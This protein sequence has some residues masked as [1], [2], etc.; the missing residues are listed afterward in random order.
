MKRTIKQSLLA[1]TMLGLGLLATVFVSLQVKQSID[2]D[3]MRQ[4]SFTCDQVTLKIRERLGDYALTLRGGV[5]LFNASN[6]VSREE[7]KAYTETLRAQDSIPGLQGIGFSLFI[8]RDQLADHIANIR[9]EGFPE[10]NVHPSGER[11]LYTSIIYLEPFR[12]R[13]M[14]AFGYDMFS[15]PVRRAAMEQARDTGEA[16]LSGKVQLVQETGAEVQAGTLMYIPVYRNGMPHDTVEQ[17]RAALIGWV[18]SPFR[19]NDLMAGILGDWERREGQAIRLEIYDGAE[20]TLASLLFASKTATT[21]DMH[22][23]F[24]LQRTIDFNGHQWLLEFDRIGTPFGIGYATAWATLAGGFALSGLLF[25]LMLSVINTQ[26][27]AA[28]IARNLTEEIRRREQLLMESEYRW[29]FALEG[30]GDGVWDWNLENDKVFFSK[31]WK[32]MLGFAEDEIGDSLDEWKNRLHPDDKDETL[33]AVQDYLNGKVPVYAHEHRMRCKGGSYKWML[34]QGM[35]VS[36]DEAGKPLRMIGTDSDFTEFK[37]LEESLRQ[38]QRELQE[39]QRIAQVGIW[40]MD[41]ATQ[42]VKWSEELYR[43]LRLSPK[44]PPPPFPEQ[45]GLFTPSSWECLNMAVSRAK[46]QGTPYELELEIIRADGSLGWTLAKGE[47]VRDASGAI[48]GLRGVTADI[49]ESK[50]ADLKLKA[51]HMETQRFR[52]ALDYVSS[53]IYMK[54]TQSRYLYA[55]RATLELFG[56]SAEELVGSD[57]YRFF[58]A[59]TAKRLREIDAR[60]FQGE[61]TTE[62]VDV[63]Y[64]KGGRRVYLEIKTPIYEDENNQTVGGLLGISTN[65]TTLKEHEQYLEHIAHYDALT[66]LAN[67][68]LFADRLHQSMA[69]ALR[70]GKQLA[71]AYI[72]LDGFKAVND[73]HGHE[74]GDH[75]LMAVAKNMKRT[76]REGDSLA[77]LGGDEFVAMLQDLS[78]TENSTPMLTRLLKAASEPVTYQKKLLQVSASVGVTFFPQQEEVDADQLLRQADHAMYQAK[79]AGKNKFHLFDLEQDRL[80][81]GHHESL[82]HIRQALANHEFV[83]YYQPKANIRTGM[84][85]GVE[86]LIRWRH[87]D[88]GLLPPAVFLPVIED[89][90]LSVEFGEWVINTTLSQMER[91][92]ATGLDIPVSVNVSAR[93]LQQINFVER[94]KISLAAHPAIE[95]S[96]LELEILETSALADLG[97]VCR[98]MEDCRDIGVSFAL[99][100][101]GTGYSSLTYLK[102]L[103]ADTLKIDQTFVHGMLEDPEDLAILEGVLGLAT[104]FHRKAIAEGVETVEHG[105]MLL[106]LGCDIAQGYGI[107]RPMPADQLSDWVSS[108]KPDPC[109]V[110]L[111]AIDRADLPLLYASVELRAWAC[112]FEAS[113]VGGQISSPPLDPHQCRFGIWLDGGGLADRVLPPVRQAIDT[114][115][116]RIHELAAEFTHLKTEGR[117]QEAK[118]R[119]NEFYG[120]RDS[121][122]EHLKVL[123]DNNQR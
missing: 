97:Q 31:R 109:W 80:A 82:E 2:A 8:P 14:R 101:F 36:R 120:V 10:Y 3:A 27:N 67:R 56:V 17:R 112:A 121:L 53:F 32:E 92:K 111:K 107:A 38:N 78:N 61:Q 70:R 12:D 95:P 26:A 98:V 117:D 79:L 34:D 81:R 69:Q 114:L 123:Q 122:L 51:A 77:R 108:W 28:R 57:D 72:D 7:W 41:F 1:W 15:E 58:P 118:E 62:E 116:Q 83:L 115:H 43:M 87:P 4:F 35:V 55:N 49:T 105:E 29:R 50:Q 18:Y 100:D 119:L 9:R 89:H 16:A 93:Q 5:A 46:D 52:K 20:T 33:R 74:A 103:S 19:M 65:I 22:E 113:L 44:M 64:A 94:L 110:G 23:P 85:V 45:I 90:P 63:P 6:I 86:A 91:W 84:I 37:N 75:L 59:D 40:Q 42:Q 24:R 104:A 13:N 25:G 73:S 48:I 76:L 54:D 68:V 88:K 66:G 71:V 96:F 11:A 21:A 47:A 39:A 99:D 102:R 60:V 106:L 30:S